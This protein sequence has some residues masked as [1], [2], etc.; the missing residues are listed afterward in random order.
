MRADRIR[1][2]A[3]CGSRGAT[4]LRGLEAGRMGSNLSSA[5]SEASSASGD[6]RPALALLLPHPGVHRSH[7]RDGSPRTAQ[8]RS[9][10]QPPQVDGH[11]EGEEDAHEEEAGA[12]QADLR[13][14]RG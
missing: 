8:F 14:R 10:R 11:L 12:Q 5:S 4:I 9:T 1:A 13:Q 3:G 7:R 6:L 2:M